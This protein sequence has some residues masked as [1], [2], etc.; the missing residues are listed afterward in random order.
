[1]ALLLLLVILTVVLPG[2]YFFFMLFQKDQTFDASTSFTYNLKNCE[3]IYIRDDKYSAANP[4][5]E[6][7]VPGKFGSS[8][9]NVSIYV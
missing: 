1:M 6:I 7:E 3:I 2:L 5:F 9:R 8:S 4:Y